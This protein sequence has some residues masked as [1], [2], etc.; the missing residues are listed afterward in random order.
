MELQWPQ[1]HAESLD[2]RL[3]KVEPV[4]AIMTGWKFMAA[5]AL[6]LV[7]IFGGARI[8]L[9]KFTGIT[10]GGNNPPAP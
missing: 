7:G 4:P 8:G 3:S 5:G 2:A 6:G 1:I 9:L 10:F